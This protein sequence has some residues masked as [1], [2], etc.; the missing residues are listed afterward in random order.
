MLPHWQTKIIQ[1]LT[2]FR[3]EHKTV[4]YDQKEA[5][6]AVSY[7]T[8]NTFVPDNTPRCFVIRELCHQVQIISQSPYY[9]RNPSQLSLDK[10]SAHDLIDCESDRISTYLLNLGAAPKS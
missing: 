10:E 8:L 2:F 1:V 6:Y 7:T 9:V 4:V 3:F 5:K